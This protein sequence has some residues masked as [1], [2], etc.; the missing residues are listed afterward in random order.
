MHELG[1]DQA[2]MAFIV[3]PALAWY[4][5]Q[6]RRLAIATHAWLHSIRDW[7]H[8][9]IRRL[10][11]SLLRDTPEDGDAPEVRRRPSSDTG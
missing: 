8:S 2:A 3:V 11:L 5:R 1:Y 7:V 10:V 9:R 6:G 4:A